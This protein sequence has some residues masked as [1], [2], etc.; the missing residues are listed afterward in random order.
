MLTGESLHKME[1]GQFRM[2][3]I[4]EQMLDIQTVVSV[5]INGTVIRLR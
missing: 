5:T 2:Q 4:C 1:Q 3:H